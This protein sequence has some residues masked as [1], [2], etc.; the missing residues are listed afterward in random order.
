[1]DE[2]RLEITVRGVVYPVQVKVNTYGGTKPS[3]YFIAEVGGSRLQAETLTALYDE[4]MRATK[5]ASVR[6]AV[7]FVQL[8]PG[9]TVKRGVVTTIHQA[10]NNLVASWNPGRGDTEQIKAYG[11]T[12]VPT[13][14]SDEEAE[15]KRLYQAERDAEKAL[16]EWIKAR[17][18]N[19][20]KAVEEAIEAKVAG[21]SETE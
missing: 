10:S 16:R 18:F 20:R 1:M 17:E 4:A 2:Q 21:A 12:Y 19:L 6:V 9:T 3:G 14:H 8:G 13:L 11:G 5:R 7:P 15:Y